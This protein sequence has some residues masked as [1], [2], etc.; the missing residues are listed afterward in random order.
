MSL[1]P[2]TV[3]IKRKRGDEPV[4]FLQVHESNGKHG[5]R[6]RRTSKEYLFSLQPQ[7]TSGFPNNNT[8]LQRKD[9][10][11]RPIKPV[12]SGATQ[13]STSNG[14]GGNLPEVAME[15]SAPSATGLGPIEEGNPAMNNTHVRRFH[16]SRSPLAN[17][18]GQGKSRKR[19]ASTSLTFKERKT[20]RPDPPG[21][22]QKIDQLDAQFLPATMSE[23]GRL[24][25][26]PG[27]AARSLPVAPQNE[28][29]KITSSPAKVMP[30][31]ATIK[32]SWDVN[33]T[34]LAAEM[35]AF[36]LE[37]IGKNIA[38]ANKFQSKLEAPAMLTPRKGTPSKFT[39]KKPALRYHERHPDVESGAD[40]M[41][42]DYESSAEDT[43]D[44]SEYIIDTYV[45]V[46]AHTL[47]PSDTPKNIGL[48]VLD[49][50]PDIDDFY[51]EGGE[52]DDEEEDAEEDENAEDHYTA[53]YP[54][55][56]VDTDDEFDRNAY[57][58]RT[59]NASDLEEFDEDDAS[60]SDDE[61]D[62]KPP[63]MKA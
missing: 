15:I 54:E 59:Y 13:L 50:Q 12:R 16:M 53:D 11:S 42:V 38:E 57:Y 47:E 44:E 7:P 18:T 10:A 2:A 41:D 31:P 35:E 30:L 48:L 23:Q 21:T 29:L 60:F 25:K 17:S 9:I 52:S 1:P 62:G 27:R 49:S 36:T 8:N 22:T 33:S 55:D 56:E 19:S 32:K 5:K 46:P 24:Q 45:R 51:T 20:K 6:Q 40:V 26:K 58:Y 4:D 34:Q 28:S 37:E 43:D 14:Q 61:N 39:P 3:R 63:W